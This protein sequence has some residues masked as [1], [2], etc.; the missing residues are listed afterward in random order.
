MDGGSPSW[1]RQGR[2]VPAQSPPKLPPLEV[3]TGHDH[4]LAAF[5]GDLCLRP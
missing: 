4:P 3:S 1:G 2:G 5:H